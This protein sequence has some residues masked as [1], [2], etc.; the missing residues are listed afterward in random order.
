MGVNIAQLNQPNSQ[1]EVWLRSLMYI[2][3]NSSST[4]GRLDALLTFKSLEQIRWL[5]VL[6]RQLNVLPQFG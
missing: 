2:P 3:T 6:R 5:R 1:G 4:L